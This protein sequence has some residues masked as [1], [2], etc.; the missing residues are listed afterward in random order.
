[1]A[2]I[3]AA[4]AKA[5]A[6]D[7]LEFINAA[8]TPY[9]AVE[10]S[11]KRLAAAGFQH[12][13]EKDAWDL[14]PGGKYYFTRNMSTIVAFAVGKKY[15]PGNPFYMIGAHTDSPCLKVKPV[16]KATGGGCQLI[17]VETYGGGLWYTWFDRDLG[18]AGRALVR[19]GDRLV[20]R[21]IKVTKPVLRI[22][23]LAIHLQ[24]NMYQ[25]GFKPNFQTNLMPLLATSG[26]AAAAAAAA[27]PVTPSAVAGA[28]AAAASPDGAAA[29]G[30]PATNG[31]AGA[32]GSVAAKHHALF[33]QLVADEL[34]CS[35]N[36]VVDFELN[37]CDVQPGVLG[38][39]AEEFVFVGRLDNLA[40]CYTAIEALCDSVRGDD[41]LDDEVAVRSLACFD[42][43]EVGS[44]SAQGAGGPVMRDTITRVARA[45]SQG[46]EGAVERALRQSFLVSADMA[47]A[48]HP[49]YTDKHDALNAPAFHGG[50][51]LKHNSNQ[52]YA[53]NAISAALF[54]GLGSGVEVGAF[55]V[56]STG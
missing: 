28:S 38:G 40:S 16:S 36:D 3:D 17:N 22:P 6:L 8:W 35:P 26:K 5:R 55:S 9:H 43:E 25:E 41:S 7:M 45:L 23:M 2:K 33:M 24:R 18:V 34:G 10:E 14:Q 4:V 37:V 32:D 50:L 54:R 53:T 15:S 13:A 56:G 21:L 29:A 12:I 52:R 19:E 48:L 42:H 49:T 46:Q 1:M 31:A 39:A 27:A 47:H 30:D 51:V 44:D 20:H 11:A